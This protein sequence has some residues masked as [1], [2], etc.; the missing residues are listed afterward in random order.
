[1]ASPARR[2]LAKVTARLGGY[3]AALPKPTTSEDIAPASKPP[4]VF[5]LK[6][7]ETEKL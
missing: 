1:M 3:G 7:F 4:L 6:D 2:E 5:P